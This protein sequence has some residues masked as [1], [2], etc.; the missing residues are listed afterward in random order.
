MRSC[1]AASISSEGFVPHSSPETTVLVSSTR[2]TSL[3]G[4]PSHASGSDLPGVLHEQ[5]TH[6]RQRA[7]LVALLKKRAPDFP[8]GMRHT[9][10]AGKLTILR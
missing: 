6:E 7:G 10:N 9:V 3:A 1:R 4:E 5:G 8:S 2:R